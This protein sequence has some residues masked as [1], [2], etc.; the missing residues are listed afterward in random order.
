MRESIGGAA[1]N[2]QRATEIQ[3]ACQLSPENALQTLAVMLE[4]PAC[5][6]AYLEHPFSVPSASLLQAE[7]SHVHVKLLWAAHGE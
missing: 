1:S 5:S 6:R 4:S 7:E 3:Q 2:R